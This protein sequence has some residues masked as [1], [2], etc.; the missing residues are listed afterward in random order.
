MYFYFKSIR[1]I[2]LTSELVAM[3]T[4]RNKTTIKVTPKTASLLKN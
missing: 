4:I 1:V 3:G 2:I